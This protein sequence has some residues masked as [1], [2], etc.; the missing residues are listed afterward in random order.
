M[1]LGVAVWG[2]RVSPVL[3]MSRRF[4]IVEVEDGQEVSR[5]EIDV[6]EDHLPCRVVRIRELGLDVL[7]CG[8]VSRP[9]AGMLVGSGISLVG[10]INGNVDDVLQDFLSGKLDACRFDMRRGFGM[11]RGFG[12]GRGFG[13]G[14]W[15]WN[16]PA[17]PVQAPPAQAP[18]G[19]GYGYQPPAM[20]KEQ[21]TKILEAEKSGLES[22][23]AEIQEE[24]KQ[25]NKR[26]QDIKKG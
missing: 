20:S 21:E 10:W 14:R 8:A 9:L 26:M 5:H 15:S 22:E 1:K 2:D 18:A 11:G 4:L 7:I 17:P 25:I 12:G 16:R 23:I 24:I 13:R 3:D 19:Y 6:R